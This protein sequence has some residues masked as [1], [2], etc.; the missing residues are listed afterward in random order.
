MLKPGQCFAVYEW[1]MTDAYNPNNEEQKRIKVNLEVLKS[2]INLLDCLR[3][4][5]Y[6]LD[7]LTYLSCLLAIGRN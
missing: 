2:F 7:S 4:F 5:V 6:M 1:C 3:A